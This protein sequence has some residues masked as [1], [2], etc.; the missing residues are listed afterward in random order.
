MR[1]RCSR[2]TTIRHED[3][4]ALDQPHSVEFQLVI[5]SG[6][7]CQQVTLRRLTRPTAPPQSL[8]TPTLLGVALGHVHDLSIAQSK[9]C[10]RFHEPVFFT[11]QPPKR[12]PFA[13]QIG[14][15][16]QFAEGR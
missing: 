5:A 16:V 15:L 2:S 10:R 12:A 14:K 4:A 9:L 3:E 1:L 7:N 8:C 11:A 13:G 6:D